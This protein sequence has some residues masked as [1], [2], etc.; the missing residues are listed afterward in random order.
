MPA[1]VLATDEFR[2]QI[3]S[4][5]NRT[6]DPN[7]GAGTVRGLGSVYE[8]SGTFPTTPLETY[9]KLHPD[10][11]AWAYQNLVNLRIFNVVRDFGAVADGV[12]S[13]VNPIRNALAAADAAG[14]GVIYFPPAP[15]GYAI[16]RVVG[17]ESII[18]V[19]NRQN[20]V[21]MG[22]GYNSWIKWT[23]NAG[24]TTVE[25]FRIFDLSERIIFFNMRFNAD[26]LTN[27]IEQTH[28]IQFAS[29]NPAGPGNQQSH[30]LLIYNCWFDPIRGDSIRTL[31]GDAAFHAGYEVYNGRFYYNTHNLNETLP[32]RA[33]ITAQRDTVSM[34]ILYNWFARSEAQSI[35]FEPNGGFGPAEWHIHNNIFEVI[36]TTD[37]AVTLS[38]C[39]AALPATRYSFNFN[40]I[41]NGGTVEALRVDR[42]ECIGNILQDRGDAGFAALEFRTFNFCLFEGN[43]ILSETFVPGVDRAAIFLFKDQNEPILNTTCIVRNNLC[44]AIASTFNQACITTRDINQLAVSGN[45]CF[46]DD[47]AGGTTSNGIQIRA[48]DDIGSE[49]IVNGNLV[50]GV[51]ENLTVGILIT[52]QDGINIG[53]VL[54]ND[55]M[56]RNTVTAIQFQSVGAGVFT[57]WRA[58]V[59]NNCLNTTTV[60]V[61]LPTANKGAT[62][63]GNAAPAAQIN[64][65]NVAGGPEGLVTAPPGSM[66]VN[67]VSGDANCVFT[68]DTG[69]GNTGWARVGPSQIIFGVLVGSAATAARFLA[70]GAG[71]AAESVTTFEELITRPGTLRNM[72]IDCDA[73]V[74]G[75]TNNYTMLLNGGVTGLDIAMANTTGTAGPDISAV[76]VVPGDRISM[77]VTKSV[78]PGTPQANIV[79]NIEFTG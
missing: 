40:I 43:I 38:G 16:Y 20:I 42:F 22:D 53:N 29:P 9:F 1:K 47:A 44:K 69:V 21:F 11:H 74:G 15:L 56:T 24:A 17:S 45:L 37:A 60:T 78:A 77:R 64:N 41:I 67:V 79:V 23:G 19:D 14:G 59:G 2:T 25:A 7:A 71:L 33:A 30:D 72:R 57:D 54:V 61:Q 65:V 76:A 36:P 62:I 35:D 48:V 12:T 31:G 3:S 4:W 63:G 8:R 10:A 46:M 34:N 6:A 73:G 52:T 51:T 39:T 27:F 66:E 75:G 5:Q 26:T 28:W 18:P 13:C 32:C 50:L 58:C 70:P 68:K 49:W 55:N